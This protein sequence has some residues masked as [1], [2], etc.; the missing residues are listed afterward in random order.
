LDDITIRALNVLKSSNIILCEDTRI[1]K[2]LLAKYNINSHLQVYND[3][4]TQE[5]REEIIRH[6]KDGKVVS[7]ISD[8]GTPLISDPG[9]KLVRQLKEMDFIVDA[10]PGASSLITALTLS[11]L[12]T[13]QFFFAGF[14]PKTTPSKEKT[15]QQLVDLKAT[16]IFFET[17]N[18]LISSLEVALKIFG[19]RECSVA[20]EL[21]KLYQ[22]TPLLKLSAMIEYYQSHKIKGEIV[23]LI[24]GD[25]NISD[26]NLDSD[27]LHN[28]INELLASNI[29]AKDTTDIL[30]KK[31]NKFINK[32]EIYKLVNEVKNTR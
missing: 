22:E 15:F 10:I 12:P 24:S 31:F 2:K 27:K 8:A 21:T 19:D 25:P 16:L 23:L 11:G 32:K 14:L 29:S 1:S 4:S 26:T 20:R 13:D 28:L 30:F 7:L 3:H 17:A 9:Y 6:I 5:K 18:R